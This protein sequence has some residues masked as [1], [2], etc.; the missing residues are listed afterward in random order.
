LG[1]VGSTAT[2]AAIPGLAADVGL[3]EVGL[4]LVGLA[5]VGLEVIGLAGS[6]FG[7]PKTEDFKKLALP[8]VL[9]GVEAY[10]FSS[11]SFFF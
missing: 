10:F 4:A 2:L 8:E 5:D 1:L 6:F 9:A 11:S 3:A 7:T